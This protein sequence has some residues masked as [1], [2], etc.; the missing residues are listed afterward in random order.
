MMRRA[1]LVGHLACLT[2]WCLCVSCGGG[3]RS[4]ELA[5]LSDSPSGPGP[6]PTASDA[7]TLRC[8]I[9]GE[10]DRCDED[11]LRLQLADRCDSY[12]EGE[13]CMKLGWLH[14]LG[15]DP[16]TA[17]GYY[18]AACESGSID[19]CTVAGYIYLEGP[20]AV[21]DVPR[22]RYLLRTACDLGDDEICQMLRG[23]EELEQ[24]DR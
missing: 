24:A 3:S 12:Q 22:G 18:E 23:Q 9:L 11:E 19:G 14:M 21:R 7:H 15:A 13:D 17:A 10:G 8:A 1:R 6:Q 2:A 5:P 16:A 4:T 20:E